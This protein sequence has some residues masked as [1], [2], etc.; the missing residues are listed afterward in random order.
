MPRPAI[1]YLGSRLQEPDLEQRA[2][3]RLTDLMIV[4]PTE[5]CP[6]PLFSTPTLIQPICQ[7]EVHSKEMP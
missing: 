4:S 1:G 6:S 2:S 5:S 3:L 7:Q